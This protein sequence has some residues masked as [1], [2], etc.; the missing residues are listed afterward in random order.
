MRV[1]VL[2]YAKVY[3]LGKKAK[4]NSETSQKDRT[5]FV[6]Y[7]FELCPYVVLKQTIRQI[8]QKVTKR[9][10]NKTLIPHCFPRL[11]AQ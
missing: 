3:H 7:F 8:E 4:P 9:K 11:S 1:S 6:I 2:S 10:V 5:C